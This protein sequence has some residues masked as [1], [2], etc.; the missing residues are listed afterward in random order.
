[1]DTEIMCSN[2]SPSKEANILTQS[3]DQY[4]FWHQWFR[5]A[6]KK[7]I[8]ELPSKVKGVPQHIKAL[9]KD[10]PCDGCLLSKFCQDAFLPSESC[11]KHPLELVHIDLIEYLSYSIDKYKY[12][13][14]T[15]NDYLSYSVIWY[16]KKKIW[17]VLKLQ[18]ICCIDQDTDWAQA[19]KHTFRL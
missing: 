15:L 16:L 5:H 14:T 1:M 12:S 10:S 9:T 8:E 2:A 4:D 11:V 13:L 7:V 6:G 18:A 3:D 19:Q 17:H